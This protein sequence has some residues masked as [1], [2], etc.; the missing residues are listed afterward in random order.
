[1]SNV[2]R[3][4]PPLQLWELEPVWGLCLAACGVIGAIAAAPSCSYQA[5]VQET[6]PPLQVLW[7]EP[8]PGFQTSDDSCW[9]RL[10][11]LRCLHRL[12]S[13]FQSLCVMGQQ[14]SPGPP[15]GLLTE[16]LHDARWH[17][18]QKWLVSDVPADL[19]NS[20]L[21]LMLLRKLTFSKDLY[22]FLPLCEQCISTNPC[23]T[24]H[25]RRYSVLNVMCTVIWLHAL[26]TWKGGVFFWFCLFKEELQEDNQFLSLFLC[27]TD[28]SGRPILN[29]KSCIHF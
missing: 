11:L 22:C 24:H 12:S 29:G 17:L 13:C 9:E 14:T 27:I 5:A 21:V 2:G 8:C 25:Y 10:L 15:I 26:L 20:G 28:L 23:I 18:F 7:T 19:Q 4:I 3:M 16:M 1:M 6:G